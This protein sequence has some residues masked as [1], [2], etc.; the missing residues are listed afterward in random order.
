MEQMLPAATT[1]ECDTLCEPLHVK[2]LLGVG[3]QGEVYEVGFSG[4]A[5]AAKWYFPKTASRDKGLAE[6]L[7]DSIRSTSP[8]DAFLWPISLLEPSAKSC[9][10]LNIP[11]GSFGYLMRL[12]PEGY[13]A[14][15]DHSSARISISMQCYSRLLFILQKP[16]VICMEKV[17]V[18]KIYRW[19]IFL[20]IPRM[21]VY[22]L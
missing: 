6:R 5:L 10:D 14:A 11:E 4:E 3:G 19:E 18:I 8:S 17:S 15:I 2:R 22:Y 12:R 7:R 1:I 16:L 20:Y 13:V 21:E 9:V